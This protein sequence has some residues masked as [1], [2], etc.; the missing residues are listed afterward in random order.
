MPSGSNGDRQ[1]ASVGSTSRY[2]RLYGPASN[3]PVVNRPGGTAVAS[4]GGGSTTQN[5]S[6]FQGT[7]SGVK[8]G[9]GE[10]GGPTLDKEYADPRPPPPKTVG[11]AYNNDGGLASNGL[12]VGESEGG[13]G[14]GGDAPPKKGAVAVASA[15]AGGQIFGLAGSNDDFKQKKPGE[16]GFAPGIMRVT[17]GKMIHN[18]CDETPLEL[19][20]ISAAI[21]KWSAPANAKKHS[22]VIHVCHRPPK[23]KKFGVSGTQAPTTVAGQKTTL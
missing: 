21:A 5:N 6:P 4:E 20:P 7:V 1:V 18:L 15:A 10:E 2:P 11:S 3:P 9:E 13:D 12:N 8:K 17:A 23:P 16:R 22:V 19:T 14:D